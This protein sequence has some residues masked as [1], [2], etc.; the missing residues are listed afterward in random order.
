MTFLTKW[1]HKI[2]QRHKTLPLVTNSRVTDM[3]NDKSKEVSQHKFES[4]LK[5]K[6]ASML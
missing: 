2:T 5:L 6:M 1:I 3:I 4:S